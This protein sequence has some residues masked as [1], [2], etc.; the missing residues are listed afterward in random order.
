[1]K[2]ILILLIINIF[3]AF[4]VLPYAQ[5]TANS[6]M[7]IGPNLGFI[8]Y[9]SAFV[10]ALIS[11]I[12]HWENRRRLLFLFAIAISLAFWAYKL[13]HLYCLGCANSG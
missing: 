13:Q 6:H 2:K 5:G 10:L 4:L 12:K 3:C 8:F 11:V 9:F 7:N 1:M